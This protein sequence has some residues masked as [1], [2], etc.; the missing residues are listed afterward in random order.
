MSE[1]VL[2][3]SVTTNWLLDDE[4]DPGASAVADLVMQDMA[5]VP[6]LWHLEVRNA[7]LVAHRRR[8]IDDDQL[9]RRLRS[10][11]SLP[12]TSDSTPNFHSAFNL[13]R[14]HSLSFYD[15][16]YLELAHRRQAALAT[17]DSRLRR[18]ALAEG[19]QTLP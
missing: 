7:L 6:Q 14:S 10:L 16:V 8:R 1:F 12:V 2:D 17:L 13:A 15:A 18:A 4:I 9:D 5:L 19:L 3:A 11:S